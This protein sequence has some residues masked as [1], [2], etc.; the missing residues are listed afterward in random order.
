MFLP[1]DEQKFSNLIG[2]YTKGKDTGN[3][4]IIVK[5]TDYIESEVKRVLM[6]SSEYISIVENIKR[7]I[8][9]AQYRAAIHANMDMLLLYHDIGCVINNHKSWG[10]K[11]IDNLA[12]DIRMAFPESKGY[13]VRN[14]KYMAKFAETYPNRE[15]V[16]Q[17]VAQIPW[18][19]NV[20]LLDKVSDT[21]EREWYIKKSAKNGW[22]RNVLVHQIESGLYQR[23]V[24]V[25]KV[26][27]FESR[28]PSPQSEL[29]A[30]TMKDPYVFDFIPFREEMLERDI[31]QAL[32][33]DVTKLLLE[34]GTGFAFL[35]KRYHLN[36]GGDDF[37]IDLL[38]YNLNLRCYVVIELKAGDFKPEYAGQLN[39]YLSAVDGILK[40]EEDNP[41]IGLLL[42]KSKNN[43]V[44]EYSLKDIS[45]PIGVSEYKVT[46]SLPNALE[47]QLPSVEDILKRI[48]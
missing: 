36:V 13:S 47:E 8:K 46:S 43:L 41:S 19:H 18:G 1:L 30:Q 40:K 24:L 33:R 26:S 5:N 21:N 23:Q 29:A 37:Y 14:L 9:A 16:Q 31:E 3:Q 6:N 10:N 32:V 34:L 22:S 12:S 15:F 35:G 48:K 4:C 2:D 28:L 27:N 38:F 25:D 20:V 11:F 17:V 44:A 7:E 42:C 39:F 45:K